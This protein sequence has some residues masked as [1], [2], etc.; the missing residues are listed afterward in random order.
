[1]LCESVDQL[2]WPSKSTIAQWYF[3]QN[4]APLCRSCKRIPSMLVHLQTLWQQSQSSTSKT[5]EQSVIDAQLQIHDECI[6]NIKVSFDLF[7]FPSKYYFTFGDIHILN[8]LTTWI[9]MLTTRKVLER[10]KRPPN[11]LNK[12]ITMEL[13]IE[14][15]LLDCFLWSSQFF[16]QT[17]LTSF[18]LSDGFKSYRSP[19]SH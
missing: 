18:A 19:W 13:D 1:M 5:L 3:L 2:C 4:W 8:S 16:S 10:A 12:G 7:C 15:L 17:L 14:G 11:D 9:R 6:H